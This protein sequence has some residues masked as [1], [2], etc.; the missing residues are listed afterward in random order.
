SRETDQVGEQYGHDLSF[1]A[2]LR[3]VHPPSVGRLVEA[4]HSQAAQPVDVVGGSGRTEPPV[5]SYLHGARLRGAALQPPSASCAADRPIERVGPSRARVLASPGRGA[6]R[7]RRRRR[8]S[9]SAR[10]LVVPSRIADLQRTFGDLSGNSQDS[11]ARSSSWAARSSNGSSSW[12]TSRRSSTPSRRRSDT[13]GT[14]S[15]RPKLV[16]RRSPRSRPTSPT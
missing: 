6:L 1:P 2:G 11:V 15:T 12:T 13:R 7:L 9:R 4:L 16:V 8:R 14:R 5:P 3:T 10:R